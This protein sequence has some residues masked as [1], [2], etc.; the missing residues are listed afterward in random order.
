MPWGAWLGSALAATLILIPASPLSATSTLTSPISSSASVTSPTTSLASP[1]L[2]L[3]SSHLL[4]GLVLG[5]ESWQRLVQA[6]G[7]SGAGS[8]GGDGGNGDLL[9]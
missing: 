6:G 1:T 8:A 7:S 4:L 3:D 2:L 5:I 9:S